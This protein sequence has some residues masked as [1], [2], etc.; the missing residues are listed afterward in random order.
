MRALAIIALAWLVIVAADV[1][2]L[3]ADEPAAE[4]GKG[5]GGVDVGEAIRKHVEATE[6]STAEGDAKK[7]SDDSQENRNLQNV[8]RPATEAQ[9]KQF[10]TKLAQ[11]EKKMTKADEVLGKL[12]E[13]Q[14]KLNEQIGKLTDGAG[15]PVDAS[16]LQKELA[17][18]KASQ[19]AQQYKSLMLQLVKFHQQ[20]GN[21]Y[22]NVYVAAHKLDNPEIDY[23][24]ELAE[25]RRTLE[26]SAGQKFVSNEII[27]AGQL[28]SIN[29]KK[30]MEQA[31]ARIIA[32]DKTNAEAVKYFE[33][34]K[35]REKEKK[36]GAT[37][38][39]GGRGS[40]NV[41]HGRRR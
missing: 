30:A 14:E 21:L 24:N 27:I 37:G 20:I 28:D 12:P 3:R 16:T 22:L 36:E 9:I 13:I 33:E 1:S 40:A 17:D 10:E 6:P 2:Q 7:D 31:Y 26:E 4:G 15:K 35:Q 8:V 29:E 38:S 18:N 25:R 23:G 32:V 19:A 5:G 41:S 34:K 11:L 39:G